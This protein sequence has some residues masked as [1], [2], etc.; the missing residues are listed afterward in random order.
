MCTDEETLHQIFRSTADGAEREG[1]LLLAQGKRRLIIWK[2]L[3]RIF[4]QGTAVMIS[5]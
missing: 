4:S 5:G 3:P 1:V 2:A